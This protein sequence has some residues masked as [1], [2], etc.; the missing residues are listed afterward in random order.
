MTTSMEPPTRS[1]VALF[2]W[3]L[4]VVCLTLA[5]GC[6]NPKKKAKKKLDNKIETC[7]NAEGTFHTVEAFGDLTRKI[8][9]STCEKE[10]GNLEMP[11]EFSAQVQVGPYTWE[12]GLEEET[13]LWVLKDVRW[14]ALDNARDRL[15]TEDP[16]QAGLERTVE[17]LGQAQEQYGESGWIRLRR[18]ETML[19]LRTQMIGEGDI[20]PLKLGGQA[21]KQYRETL[22][23]AQSQDNRDVEAEARLIVTDYLNSYMT[24]IQDSKRSLGGK[25]ERYEN[26]I[27]Q[28]EENGNDEQAEKYRKTLEKLKEER[29]KKRKRYNKRLEATR[30]ALCERYTDM[31]PSG[32]EDASLKKRVISAKDSLECATILA[33]DSSDEDVADDE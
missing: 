5:A 33:D 7:R 19:D 22:E 17:L 32:I 20:E 23:W 10:A 26:V 25:T 21:R 27:E 11:D 6:S 24:Y 14:D 18:L 29:P 28:A 9:Q 16:D 30:T 15:D 4:L 2:G 13:G 12:L 3:S 8:L 31:V 1:H